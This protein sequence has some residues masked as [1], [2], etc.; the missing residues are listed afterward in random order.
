MANL[1]EP[2]LSAVSSSLEHFGVD[3]RVLYNEQSHGHRLHLSRTFQRSSDASGRMKSLCR[4]NGRHVSLKTLRSVSSPLF[5]RVDVAT[6]SAALSK[7]SSRLAMIDVGV[8]DVVKRKCIQ[9]RG[10]YERAKKKRIK[11]ETD[12][13]ERV[14][15]VGM[16]RDRGPVNEDDMELLQHWV[17]ELGES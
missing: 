5:T 8:S 2:H 9:C 11:I 7:S 6:A 15:P 12:L 13:E 10:E 4:I 1:S 3:P 17:D 16:Q 14:L